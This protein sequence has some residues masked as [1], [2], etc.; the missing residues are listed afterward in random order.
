[1]SAYSN[2]LYKIQSEIVFNQIFEHAA[3]LF[4][5]PSQWAVAE[6]PDWC[7]HCVYVWCVPGRAE[8][9]NPDRAWGKRQHM[10][11]TWTFQKHSWRRLYCWDL[12]SAP[13]EC[14]LRLLQSIWKY[15]YINC[16]SYTSHNLKIVVHQLRRLDKYFQASS[17]IQF[18][19]SYVNTL[20]TNRER[21]FWSVYSVWNFPRC[22][23]ILLSVRALAANF[24]CFDYFYY[25]SPQIRSGV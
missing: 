22:Y 15:K 4:C 13:P 23:I 14:M 20:Q 12:R 16:H 2:I 8:L 10:W 11:L 6:S 21:E 3:T 1:M 18:R 9:S 17:V 7:V 25:G 19:R 5:A 24:D